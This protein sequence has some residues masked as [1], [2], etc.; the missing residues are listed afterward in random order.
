[1]NVLVNWN[2][3]DK[4][5]LFSFPGNV[6]FVSVNCLGGEGGRVK[7]AGAWTQYANIKIIFS[8]KCPR[9]SVPTKFLSILFTQLMS[10]NVNKRIPTQ[11][12]SKLVRVVLN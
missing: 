7:V 6:V 1:M 10:E 9:F 3:P 8:T 5:G 2:R 12:N 11:N 4:K